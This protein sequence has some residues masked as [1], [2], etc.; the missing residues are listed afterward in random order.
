MRALLAHMNLRGGVAGRKEVV[1]K[2]SSGGGSCADLPLTLTD[3][4]VGACERQQR[5]ALE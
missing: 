5:V 3:A 1:T 4:R 2:L